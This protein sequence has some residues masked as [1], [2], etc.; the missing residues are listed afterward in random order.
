MRGKHEGPA[1]LRPTNGYS[2]TFALSLLNHLLAK[3]YLRQGDGVYV[4]PD[5]RR[6]ERLLNG[7]GRLTLKSTGVK[8][9]K[10]DAANPPDESYDP[11]ADTCLEAFIRLISALAS[12]Q[13]DSE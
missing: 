1:Q 10:L 12:A 11:T 4:V 3:A 13:Q 2:T 9:E 5:H 7:T 8:L 6:R